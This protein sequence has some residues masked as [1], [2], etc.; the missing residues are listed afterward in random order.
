[1][2]TS[3]EVTRRP[4]KPNYRCSTG[5]GN[6]A[7]EKFYKMATD[8]GYY[9][10]QDPK[11]N[12]NGID[13]ITMAVLEDGT[14]VY[15]NIQITIASHQ[16]RTKT[17]FNVNKKISNIRE[18]IDIVAILIEYKAPDDKPNVNTLKTGDHDIWL[19]IPADIYEHPMMYE[20]YKPTYGCWG[21]NPRKPFA[22]PLNHACDAWQFLRLKNTPK[23][24]FF[25]TKE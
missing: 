1:M 24:E 23:A 19:L 15:K 13:C 4:A 14:Q 7:E 3:Q 10:M 5:S 18:E 9:C 16:K 11:G 8:A 6:I 20:N 2:P 12:D 17:S 21:V 22:P 25:F